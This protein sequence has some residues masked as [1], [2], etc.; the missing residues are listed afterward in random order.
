MASLIRV[1]RAKQWESC[2]AR[3]RMDRNKGGQA[4]APTR[5]MT[6]ESP[7]HCLPSLPPSTAGAVTAATLHHQGTF[8]H[9]A[10]CDS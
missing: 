6:R 10:P 1:L 4:G 8:P 7:Q 3:L 9:P 5:D 2:R